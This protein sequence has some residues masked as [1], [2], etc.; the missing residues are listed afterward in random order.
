MAPADH[1]TSKNQATGQKIAA[2]KDNGG[3]SRATPV[4]GGSKI[5]TRS[6]YGLRVIHGDSASEAANEGSGSSIEEEPE[7]EIEFS[8]QNVQ[9]VAVQEDP[10]NENPNDSTPNE[11]LQEDAAT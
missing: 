6:K 11:D 3:T 10:C 2:G 5:Q 8:K 1:S 4:D 7:E 9:E